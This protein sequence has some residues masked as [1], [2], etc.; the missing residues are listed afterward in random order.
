MPKALILGTGMVGSALALIA[1]EH[2]WDATALGHGDFELTEAGSV[3]K[4]VLAAEPD[5]VFHAAALTRVNYCQEHPDEAMAVNAVGT[6]NVVAAAA[7]CGAQLV[8]FSTDYVFD[9][10]KGEPYTEDDK[11]SPVNEYGRSK[12]DGEAHA[13]A[14][15]RGHI[16]RTSGVFGPRED[17][18]ERNFIRAIHDALAAGSGPVEVVDDQF[19][20]ITYAPHLARMCY[21][22]PVQDWPQLVHLTSAGHGSWYDWACRVERAMYT[23]T[24]RVKPVPLKF[25]DTGTPRPIYSV[26]HSQ[27]PEVRQLVEWYEAV[28]A[29]EEYLGLLD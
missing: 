26:L 9:G 6:A 17:G 21:A 25:R 12:L 4:A 24:Y 11:P 3:R 2:G 1:P 29:I 5:A 27:Y 8:Y 19:T 10:E 14:Y 15:D 22:M 16:V 13:L 18:F 23:G 7:E 28:A 20:A